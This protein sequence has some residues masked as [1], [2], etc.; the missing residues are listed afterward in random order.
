MRNLFII[1][2]AVVLVAGCETP[3]ADETGS[4]VVYSGRSESLV[5]PLVERFEAAT[6]LDVEVRYGG[7][8]ELAVTL[9][10]EGDQSPADVFWAQD[11]GALGAVKADGLLLPLPD[12]LLQRVPATYR[13]NDGLWVATSGRARTLAYAPAR[14]DTSALPQSIFD[15]TDEAYAGR[16]GWAPTNGS[17]QAHVT[18]L[19]AL[20]G[21][22]ATRAWLEGMKNNGA[23]AYA[24]N[25]AILQAI[26][27]GEVDYGLPN[28]Y[29]LLRAKAN[30]PAYPVEQTFFASGDPGNLINIAGVGL[31]ATSARQEAA[32]RFVNFL[33]SDEAQRYFIDDTREYAVAGEAALR[34]DHGA[35]NPA[36]LQATLDLNRLDDLDATLE[37]LRAV[38][39]L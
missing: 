23:K 30:D 2:L 33:L 11:A 29:Y 37:M 15:L 25:R 35:D 36:A 17:F 9:A 7:T 13:S 26:A 27:D 3:E 10:E 34:A 21:D 14:V 1:L 22:E 8:S 4:L 19:R 20:A 32:L 39:L 24:N 12:T 6:G 5:E 31:L 38:G 16:V 18:A 28:H